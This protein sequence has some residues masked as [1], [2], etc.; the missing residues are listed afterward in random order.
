MTDRLGEE[1]KR[2][3]CEAAGEPRAE[4][5]ARAVEGMRAVT[6]ARAR[7]RRWVGVAVAA[8]MVMVG[9]GLVSL[10]FGNGSRE[11]NRLLA[12]V[13]SAS[14]I[15]VI[16]RHIGPEGETVSETWFADGFYRSEHR[17]EGELVRL[18]LDNDLPVGRDLWYEVRNGEKRGIER[19]SR[20]RPATNWAAMGPIGGGGDELRAT[21]TRLAEGGN[22][23]TRRLAI[24]GEGGQADVI[25]AEMTQESEWSGWARKGDRIK[26][27]AEIDPKT[28]RV[29]SIAHYKLE[30]D[31][32]QLT[33]ETE[34]IEYDVPIP[35]RVKTFTF[36]KGTTVAYSRWWEG[37][38]DEV[39]AEG[40]SDGW[41]V[42]VHAL[43]VDTNGDVYVTFSLWSH[44]DRDMSG[45]PFAE[46]I[47]NRQTPYGRFPSNTGTVYDDYGV[48]VLR[49]EVELSPKGWKP[50][51]EITI[52][53][54]PREDEEPLVLRRLPLPPASEVVYQREIV[55]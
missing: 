11:W 18:H 47:D 53:F 46:G 4:V 52:T 51:T 3:V 39:I 54:W 8:G 12:A 50:P 10:P 7:S 48:I 37:R 32:W 9:L 45:W 15:H 21:L 25:E 1:I 55:Y 5:R 44:R 23:R 34:S 22:V 26:V 36:P 13:N 19:A 43:D 31:E 41:T 17:Q 16:A 2:A 6:P 33:Y 38:T 29:L 24:L 14:T 42:K 28:N 20:P 49:P 35:D 40:K 27:R 30:G